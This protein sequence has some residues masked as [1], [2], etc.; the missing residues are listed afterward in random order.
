MKPKPLFP[1]S[2]PFYQEDAE[3]TVLAL[4]FPV[5]LEGRGKNS[6]PRDL[7]LP[8]PGYWPIAVSFSSRPIQS[9]VAMNQAIVATNRI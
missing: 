1:N 7:C 9:G 4:V 5:E 2:L 6:R 3:I 8:P